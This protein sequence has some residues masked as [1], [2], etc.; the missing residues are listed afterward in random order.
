[1]KRKRRRKA[2]EG[3]RRGVYILPNLLT[4]GCLVG[5]FYAIIAAFNGD[6]IIAAIAIMIAFFFDGVD[7]RVARLTKTTSRFGVEYDS[8]ADLVAFGVAPGILVFTWALQPFGRV[9][10]LAAFLYVACGA[11]R[12]ARFNV[13]ADTMES[14]FFRG[15]PIPMAASMIAASVFLLHHLGEEGE[16]KHL[17]L[18]ILIYVLAFL[19]VSNIRYPSFK[20]LALFKRKPFST[21]VA[22]ILIIV[23]MVAQ[24]VIMLF[25]FSF[26]YFL[27]GPVNVAGDW[28]KKRVAGLKKVKTEK[29]MPLRDSGDPR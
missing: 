26:I 15:L 13:Q 10:W 29:T 21:L 8:L 14:R 6:Y 3:V 16:T 19:M 2:R 28:Y 9:G 7:G 20:D 27:I 18:L 5:G 4:S 22:M 1:V 12:L 11:L 17:S 24:P 23:V 25:T